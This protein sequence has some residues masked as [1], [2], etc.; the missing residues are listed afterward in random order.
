MFSM[1]RSGSE[2]CIV[3]WVVLGQWGFF[4]FNFL[5]VVDLNKLARAQMTNEK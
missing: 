2:P 3:N 4:I 1:L 5:F